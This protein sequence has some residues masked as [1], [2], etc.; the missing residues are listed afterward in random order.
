M[1]IY[2]DMDEQYA[3]IQGNPLCQA[4]NRHLTVKML[5]VMKNEGKTY[6]FL[7]ELLS[8]VSVL[9]FHHF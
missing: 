8:L 4:T 3:N 7:A 5:K 9:I 6:L 2:Y 1:L